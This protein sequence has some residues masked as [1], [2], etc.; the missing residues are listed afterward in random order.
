MS[1]QGMHDVTIRAA[2]SGDSERVMGLVFGVLAEYGLS[3]DPEGEDAELRDLERI[4]NVGA[5]CLSL[6]KTRTATCSALAVCD[7]WTK[8]LAS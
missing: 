5:A 4:I 3:P 2:D 8:K 1:V 6:L 7:R